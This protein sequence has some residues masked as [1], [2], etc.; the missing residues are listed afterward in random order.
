MY[1]AYLFTLY[2]LQHRRSCADIVGRAPAYYLRWLTAYLVM[3]TSND[4]AYCT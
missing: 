2:T 4:E 3:A 1:S